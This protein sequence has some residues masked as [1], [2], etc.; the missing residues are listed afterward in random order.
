MFG[1]ALTFLSSHVVDDTGDVVANLILCSVLFIGILLNLLIQP[2][3]RRQRA[4][5]EFN[6]DKTTS[7]QLVL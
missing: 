1:M 6:F 5:K 2:D 3:L 7:K 4:A